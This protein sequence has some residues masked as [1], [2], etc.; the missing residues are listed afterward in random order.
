MPGEEQVLTAL[1][2]GGG[3]S[4]LGKASF[5]FGADM[6]GTLIKWY[7]INKQIEDSQA[8]RA[9]N[10]REYNQS[11]GL[12][13]KVNLGNLALGQRRLGLD[14]QALGLN[15]QAQS[16]NQRM[17]KEQLSMAK[18]ETTWNRAAQV[19]QSFMDLLNQNQSWRDRLIQQGI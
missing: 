8:S 1:G 5:D 4:G 10:I 19:K 3:S 13:K 18:E 12:S 6:F 14:T 9:E 15:R 11:Y 2:G 7:G 16:F 17:A